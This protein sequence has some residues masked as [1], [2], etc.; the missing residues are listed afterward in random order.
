MYKISCCFRD[1]WH[2]H[3]RENTET[4][5]I[6]CFVFFG[7]G[8]GGGGGIAKVLKVKEYTLAWEKS[9]NCRQ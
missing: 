8:G 2:D 5:I 9:Y 6:F 1:W 7:G 4:I 3:T